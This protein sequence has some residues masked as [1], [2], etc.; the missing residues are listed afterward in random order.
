LDCLGVCG[1]FVGEYKEL[2]ASNSSSDK[3]IPGL[4]LELGDSG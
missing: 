3:S 1:E 2:V 4:G